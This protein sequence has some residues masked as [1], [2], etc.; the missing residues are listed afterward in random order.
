MREAVNTA[1]RSTVVFALVALAALAPVAQGAAKLT[2]EQAA[3]LA[4]IRDAIEA[5]GADWIAA[6][7]P[8]S[9]LP[10]EEFRKMLGGGWPPEVQAI[11][12]TLRPRPE[13]LARD[14]PTY[15]DWRDM[16]GMTP[17]KDQGSCG[18]CWDFAATGALEG[19]LHVNEGVVYDLSE[20]Q[21]LDCNDG[22]SSCD[23]GWQGD[24]YDVFTDPGAVFESC[25]PYLGH[26]ST[27]SQRLCETAAIMD[28]YQ[29]VAGNVSSYKAALMEGPISACYT[30]YEDFDEYSG[31]C[32]QHVWGSATAGHCIVIAGWDDSM[33]GGTGAWI[34]KNSWGGGWGTAGYFYIKYGD[35]GIGTGAERPLN[36]HIP[37]ERLVPDEF[38]TIQG[39]ID[40]SNR[41]DVIRVAGGTYNENVVVGDYRIIYGGYDPAFQV[42]DLDAYPTIIDAGVS[43][44]GISITG[45]ENVVLDGL[46]IRNATGATRYGVYV[47]GSEATVRNCEI[48]DSYRGIFVGGSAVDGDA[49][50]ERCVVHDNEDSGIYLSGEANTNLAVRLTA[51]Y[52]NGGDG[53]YSNTTPVSIENCTL[54]ANGGDGVDL[55]WTSGNVIRSSIICSNDG[56]GIYCLVAT[57]DNSYNCVWDNTSGGYSGCSAGASSMFVDPIFCDAE[58]GDV[59]VHATSPTL[60]A[61]FY[62]DD[63]GALGIGCPE[64]PSGLSVAQDGAV[65]ELSW[66]PPPSRAEVDH[67][68]VYRDTVQYHSTAVA[69]VEAPVTSFS[70]VTIPPCITHNYWVSSVD[71]SGLE[72]A[73]SNR[74]Y[75]ELCYEGPYDLLAEFDAGGNRLDWEPG[76]GDIDRY[77]I[78]RATVIDPA[79][80]VGSVYAPDTEFRDAESDCPRDNYIY[81]IVPVYDTG[82]RGVPSAMVEVDPAPAPPSGLSVE[83]SGSDCVLNWGASCES[84]FRRYY[85][86]RD[87]MPLSPPPRYEFW[88]GQTTDTTFVDAGLN[89]DWNYFY[90]LVSS[91]ASFKRSAYSE[92]VYV[93]DPRSRQVP[94]EF[95][96]I[97]DAIDASSPPDTVVVAPGTYGENIVLK[98]GVIVTSSGGRSATTISSSTSPVVSA[99]GVCDLTRLSGFT[100]DGQGSAATGLQCWGSFLSV[101]DCAFQGCAAGASFK[102]GGAAL[103]SRCGFAMNQY[104]VAVADSSVPFL[105][106]NTF[107][108]NSVAA[109]SSSGEPGPEIGRTLA[110]ANDFLNGG[111]FQ[112][113]NSGASPL[114]ADYN[115]W[116]DAC[117]DPS[118]FF[119][120]VSYTPWTDAA[121]TETYTSCTGVPD[122][123]GAERAYA[124]YNYPNPF[125]PS[126]A[127]R[128]TVP[129]PGGVVSLKI[130]DLGGRLI[131]TLVSDIKRGGDHVVVWNGRNDGGREVG[132]GIYFYRL[133]IG[134]R[135]FERKMV[136]L[137]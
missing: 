58:G 49:V 118:W 37:R 62:G 3:E 41:G 109:V 36:A 133:E 51:S 99:S 104:G 24:A 123:A 101:E 96:T 22:W 26:E 34:C 4:A 78:M 81:E 2:S 15:W 63:M 48:H 32:Y 120:Q 38:A 59:T 12:D 9:L 82:W 111:Y 45:R 5:K 106:A 7:N 35:S 42:R 85:V 130:Y 128:Y 90:R 122:D 77:E 43:G 6:P 134:A 113:F 127:I 65:L 31:G 114:D 80:S 70:D 68:V 71:T 54:A 100:I 126:T 18:S 72:G 28:G 33:C 108:S 132:S 17:V 21:G 94:A 112:V 53:L 125:N 107:D 52:G 64:G 39:A 61:G 55:R 16:S 76:Q 14:Y 117:P 131:R 19:N 102:F 27:C 40:G 86:Y 89:T 60:D 23:G 44:H 88:V 93:A 73:V 105:F 129:S 137:K 8:I 1:A 50:I 95:A 110:D 57:P 56:Y 83:W 10:K 91:D 20:Q 87:T 103:V 67:Y 135:S 79:D 98:N 47:S 92:M 46:E 121:H 25:M 69:I 116:G 115:Y 66:D 74:A 124:S 84:D 29:Y 136:L 75:A 119:G 13:D 97:Q 30:V 11:F